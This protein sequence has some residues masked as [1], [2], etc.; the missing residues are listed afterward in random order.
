[1]S[2]ASFLAVGDKIGITST[3]SPVHPDRLLAGLA[4]LR[5]LGY[6]PVMPLDPSANFQGGLSGFGCATKEEKVS[7][8]HSLFLDPEVKVIILARGGY[9]TQEILPL[10]DFNLLARHPKPIVG[11]SDCTPLLIN[12]FFRSQIPAIHGPALAVEFSDYKTNVSAK[13]SVDDLLALL[14]GRE[15]TRRFNLTPV[16]I[17]RS[18]SAAEVQIEPVVTGPIIG[19]NLSLLAS[20]VGTP[21]DVSYDGTILFVED[22]GEAPYRIHRMFTQLAYAGKLDNLKAL[23][24]GDFENC[25]ALGGPDIESTINLIVADLLADFSYPVFTGLPVGHARR[26]TPIVLGGI[27][28]IRG[29]EMDL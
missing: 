15:H 3:G 2:K 14:T 16:V 19:G 6:E 29:V 17:Q 18:S 10:I 7:A 25:K 24:F 22:T 27:T 5:D 12:S 21:W 20:A 11:F 1:M 8:L 28:V 23:V 4:V 26:N 9:S 13:N